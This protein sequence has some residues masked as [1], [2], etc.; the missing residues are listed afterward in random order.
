M[1]DHPDVDR[2]GFLRRPFQRSAPLADTL[3]ISSAVIT[4]RPERAA[5]IAR[6]IATR[7]GTPVHA[8]AGSKIEVVLEAAASGA[9][10][11][12]LIEIALMDGVFSA[13]M[14]F[15]QADGEAPGGAS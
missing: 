1:A 5:D 6:E 9:D 8:V 11:A 15:E 13:N 3:H 10:G 12:R 14:V 4:V 2:R 7:R